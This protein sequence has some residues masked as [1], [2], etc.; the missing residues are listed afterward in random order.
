MKMELKIQIPEGVE[1]NLENDEV[2]VKGPKGEVSRKFANGFEITKKDNEL[3]LKGKSDRRKDKA[4]LGTTV[5]HIKNMIHGVTDGITYRM[6][7]V[8][9]HFPVNLKVQGN[10]LLID[11][12]MGENHPRRT[13]ILDGV[14]VDIKGQDLTITGIDKE[15]VSQ[16]AANIEQITRV[17]NK[18]LRV[19][20]DGIYITEKDGKKLV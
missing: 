17:K 9:S 12:F 11:N 14:N 3:M 19:F 8:Y 4:V 18:D 16:T 20:Q 1:I 15:K 7:V 10:Q 6:K 5:A 2:K 13:A